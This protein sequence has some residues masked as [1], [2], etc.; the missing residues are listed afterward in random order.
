MVMK[1]GNAMLILPAERPSAAFF[2][3]TRPLAL[4]PVLGRSIADL[5]IEHVAAH[6]AR[7]VL[8]LAVDRPE[9]VRASIGTGAQWGVK[10]EIS[11]EQREW[12]PEEAQMRRP[13]PNGE[14][15]AEV[16]TVDRIPGADA[17]SP[18]LWE[19]PAA[20]WK[21][22]RAEVENGVERI[23][24]REMAPGVFV[25]TRARLSDA[26]RLVAPCWIGANVWAGPRTVIGPG[27][28]VE[29]GAYIDEGAT[30]SESWIGPSTYVGALTEINESLAW[31]RGLCKWPT[32]SF[33]EVA[34]AFLLS[35][36]QGRPVMV[37]GSRWIGRFAAAGAILATL[38]AVL[39]GWLRHRGATGP[40][41]IPKQAVRAPVRPGGLLET[42]TYFELAGFRGKW[43]RWP[44]LI[45]VARGEFAWIGNRPVARETA[46]T[47]HDDFERLWLAVR[48][49]LFSLAD[50]E[51]CGDTYSDDAKAHAGF[52][53]AHPT[54][55]GDMKI[56]RRIIQRAMSGNNT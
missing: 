55:R 18:P 21:T 33:T 28:V 40:L 14:P 5:W 17:D 44:E 7:E 30:I 3:R 24:C 34:D 50:A 53:A 2:E 35:D 48:T 41:F 22:V 11:P 4:V 45:N 56:L 29:E 12:R 15:W 38:P 20:F 52:Y 42:T 10:A 46:E 19:S 54:L 23:G 1:P 16:A 47:F 32:G 26:T 9:Q 51:G 36:L 31:G 8:L 27:A 39:I 13:G 37:E 6:G 49:G 25:S 43:K